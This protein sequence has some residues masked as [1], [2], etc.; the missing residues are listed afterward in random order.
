M[1]FCAQSESYAMPQHLITE[2]Q[3]GVEIL[4]F[5]KKKIG[6]EV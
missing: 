4:H 3:M 2:L 6:K 1:Y 5:K